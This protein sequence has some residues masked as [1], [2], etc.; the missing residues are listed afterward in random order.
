[1]TVTT[2]ARPDPKPAAHETAGRKLFGPFITPAL[3]LYTAVLVVPT[4]YTGYL[5]F[6][7]WSGSG[8]PVWA[9]LENYGG[10]LS[11]LVD[12]GPFRTA[13]LNTLLY[14]V[15]GGV[16]TFALA[17]LFAMVL[18]D[19]KGSRVIR[20]VLFFPNI[21]APLAI[22]MFFGI[23]FNAQP[24]GMVNQVLADLG[25]SEPFPFL[26]ES[27]VRW[28]TLAAVMWASAGFFITILMSAIDRIPPYLYEDASI[29]GASS[30]QKFRNITFPMISDVVTIAGV[31]WTISAI[32]IFEMV[33]VMAGPGTYAPPVGSW[34]LGLEVYYDTFGSQGEGKFGVASAVAVVM[35]LLVIVFVTLL[36]RM[37]R[38]E[39][40]QY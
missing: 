26:N 5:S 39:Q 25:L 4:V 13:L 16:G 9:G 18:A 2:Q 36:R 11:E 38:R 3:L 34:T 17:F 35:L 20:A 31:L 23:I 21:V 10:L 1:M 32:K 28:L 30:W 15:V 29:A 27:N 19:M 40:L 14:I 6:T 8:T 12:G 33:W 7:D 22:G 24:P 37:S